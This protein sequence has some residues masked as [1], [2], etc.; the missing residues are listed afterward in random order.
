L[1][2]AALPLM[3]Q[4]VAGQG[5]TGYLKV[6]AEPSRA[7]VFVD[8]KYLGPAANFGNKRKYALAPGAHEV[9]LRDPRYR[10]ATLKATIEAGKTVTL[11]QEL[12][13]APVPMPP[14][15]KLQIQAPDKFTAVY[16]NGSFMGHV[17]EF[18]HGSQ[19]LLL[20]PNSYALRLVS[21]DG[22]RT[23]E[24]KVTLTADK[25]TKIKWDGN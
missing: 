24:E 8:G 15:G 19:R 25:T 17:G 23:H 11:K 16:A 2:A 5:S 9:V 4:P 1:I 13:K 3:L 18:D 6:D 12:E 22:S 20:P 14:F 10:P 21:P 7:G